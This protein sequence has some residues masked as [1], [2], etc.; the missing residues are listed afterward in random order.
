MSV[1]EEIQT[2]ELKLLQEY[3]DIIVNMLEAILKDKPTSYEYFTE[4]SQRITTRL[5]EQ[6]PD[7]IF[8]VG[9]GSSIHSCM[10]MGIPLS[11]AK[12]AQLLEQQS[13]KRKGV[14]G[15]MVFWTKF[16]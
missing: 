8:Y 12:F 15:V 2:T 6:Y 5:Q 1:A 10:P 4:L 9:K 14:N 16:L 13:I 7:Y 3:V 11:P